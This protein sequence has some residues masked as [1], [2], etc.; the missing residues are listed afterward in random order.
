MK[1]IVEIIKANKGVSAY[2]VVKVTNHSYELFFVQKNLETV[3][4][5][6]SEDTVVTIYV[7]HDGK[8]GN[9]A[10]S[11]YASTDEKQLA[12][13]VEKAVEKAKLINDQAYDLPHGGVE[14][15]DIESNISEEDSKVLGAKIAKAVFDAN[16]VEDC[17]INALEIFVTQTQRHVVN[18]N[19]IDKTQTKHTISIEAI[20]T[21][22]GE[23]E[24][25]ELFETYTLAEFDEQWIAKEIGARM[26]DV[27]ARLSAVRPTEKI[28]CPIV[29]NPYELRTLFSE[30]VDQ[31]QYSAV[32][33]HSA[34]FNVGD[35]IQSAP[36]HDKLNVT[37]RGIIKG[38]PASN[39]FDG[40]GT[41]LK[42]VQ[43]IKDGVL[44]ANF[45]SS[46]FAQYL[47]K[48]ATGNLGCVEVKCGNTPCAVLTSKPHLECVYLSGLQ[49]DAYNDY[50]GGEIRL[51]YLCD[52]EKRTPVTGISMSG[53]LSDVLNTVVLSKERAIQGGY[54]G[55]EKILIDKMNIF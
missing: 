40:D 47:G 21:A 6:V 35:K 23:K 31:A 19:G 18:S 45:G 48:E 29:L 14:N 49:V 7:D 13:K 4:K 25:V 54:C 12:E 55:P 22:N 10:F 37:M 28:E 1:N 38:S 46:R 32:Y 33:M 39:A 52:G 8:R 50:I 44:C 15:V 5:A 36:E 53:K 17:A 43:I 3:R 16:D 11:V 41:T 2:N 34:L 20:P 30:I 51:A 26:H 42:D 9:S 24:S 27:K